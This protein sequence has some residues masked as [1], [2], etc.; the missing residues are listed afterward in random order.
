SCGVDLLT[1]SAHKFYGP[2]GT[3]CLY[4]RDG[5]KITPLLNGGKQERG[6]RAGTENVPGIIGMT[7]ALDIVC[8]EM[9]EEN[10]RLA[11]LRDL[12]QT[13]ILQ[14]IPG[15]RVNGHLKNRLDSYLNVLLPQVEARAMLV[16]LDQMG[17]EC[18]AGSAC[19]TGS[20]HPSHVLMAMGLS[21][22]EAGCALRFTLGAST[23]KEQ[24]LYTLECLEKI[25]IRC[26]KNN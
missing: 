16:A 23:T 15:A 5:V 2:K 8:N 18:S 10:K 4:V 13:G 12:L 11:G 9:W 21:E 19:S 17:I 24:I 7:V 6:R 3:G 26:K 25:C 14:S 1:L 22:Q 20:I